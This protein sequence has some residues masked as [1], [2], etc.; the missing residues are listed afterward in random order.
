[1]LRR[2]SV[3]VLAAALAVASLTGC[4]V[5]QDNPAKVAQ[6]W[7]RAVAKGDSATACQVQYLED[8]PMK[9]SED[10][11]ACEALLD[12]V[13]AADVVKLEVGKYANATVTGAEIS[14][15]RATVDE[16]A[17]TGV[18]DGDMGDIDLVKVDG[19]WWVDEAF[20]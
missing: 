3:A 8:R 12:S 18:I 1:M 7:L 15:D 20:S 16:D 19:D 4:G 17:I 6:S 5:S 10:R 9:S 14:E 11:K 13:L 2:S